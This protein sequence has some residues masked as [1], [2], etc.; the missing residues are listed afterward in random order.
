MHSS[1]ILQE[2]VI[3]DVKNA[4]NTVVMH[5]LKFIKSACDTISKVTNGNLCR[6][7]TKKGNDTAVASSNHTFMCSVGLVALVKGNPTIQLRDL[8]SILTQLS[9]SGNIGNLSLLIIFQSYQN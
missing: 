9:K 4:Q 2:V 3:K 8:P 7:C 6:K 1:S 5:V